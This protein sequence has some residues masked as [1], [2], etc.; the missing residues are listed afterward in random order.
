MKVNEQWLR[1]WSDTTLNIADLANELTMAGL[2]VETIEA[3]GTNKLRHIVVG[4]VNLISAHP[5][6]DKLQVCEVNVGKSKTLQIVCG[7]ANVVEQGRYPVALVGAELPNGLIIKPA[8]LRNIDSEGMLCS[9]EEL[10]LSDNTDGLF[11]L[12][13]D[14]PIGTS[15]FKY[16][17]LDDNVIE[18]GL[19]P[20]RGDCLSIA[21]V[22]R[23]VSVLTG[24]RY[25]RPN[26]RPVK[27]T[28]KRKLTV[29]LAQK[30]ACPHYVGR[31]IEG[32]SASAESPL[33]IKEKLRRCGLR[34]ISATVD[35]TNYVLLE[36]G[37]PMHAFDHCKLEGGIVVRYA[38]DKESLKLLDGKTIKLDN[39]TLIIADQSGPVALAGIMGGDNTA[40]DD[41]TRDI[42][43]ESAY[44][45]PL[46]VAGKARKYA[47]HTDSSHRFE[48]GVDFTL[49]V[50]ALERATSLI[51]QIAGGKAGPIVEKT[52]KAQLPKLNKIN[53]R[54]DRIGRILGTSIPKAKVSAILKKLHFTIKAQKQG[55]QV[56]APS[57]RF[58]VAQEIDLIEEIARIYG[59]HNIEESNFRAT[60]HVLPR[61]EA[62]VDV[63]VFSSLLVARGYQEAITYSFVDPEL[64]MQ[65][66]PDCKPISLKNP[67]S[68]DMA[69]MRT[70]LWPG[71]LQVAQYNHNRQQGR[72]RL[73]E[74]GQVFYKQ[75]RKIIHVEQMAGLI[76]GS[77]YPEQWGNNTKVI[78]FYDA[79]SD[80]EALLS[81]C[82]VNDRF[83]FNRPSKDKQ[84]PALHP[85]QT[86]RIECKPDDSSD[87][88]R[89]IGWLGCLH[90]ELQ[91]KLGFSEPVFLFE[92]ELSPIR[93]R[94]IPQYT[95]LSKFPTI[96]RDLAIVVDENV[97]MQSIRTCVKKSAS[98]ILREF[99]LFDEYRGK[100]IDSGRKSLAFG[101]TLQK[102]DR[103]LKDDEVD[104]I[105]ARVMKS[106]EIELGATLRE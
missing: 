77:V 48:R 64:Q 26:I 76:T 46:T 22:A 59:Y 21:G 2:E 27:P 65:I 82:G 4:Q 23:E 57:F 1:E 44:F 96:R 53:L 49:Q 67:I 6:A 14:A 47:L 81:V 87:E 41:T 86:A 38:Q 71:L 43:L 69:D 12:P 31:I 37:Q 58:D 10:G 33:W 106:L 30:E 75:G 95:A 97:N 70:S 7:A 13:E 92:V 18:L 5:N 63:S 80:L 42:F 88:Q 20:N 16:L 98:N 99:Q 45:N 35:I 52:A 105:V 74:T 55:W 56:V 19:T 36:L 9:S 8:K 25:K 100:G 83:S 93:Q 68:A 90:P 15:I 72:I 3:L 29:T 101:L 78:D 89:P 91:A 11:G 102:Q 103:T 79:K 94:R 84:H 85:G 61:P 60:A 50:D 104:T 24:C 51:L 73:F 28:I 54:Y 66:L 62:S 17:S 39:E 34:S 40:V 32:I